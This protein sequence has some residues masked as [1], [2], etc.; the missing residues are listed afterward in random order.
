MLTVA[1][2]AAL[3]AALRRLSRRPA[4]LTRGS[5]EARAAA[6]RLG[7]SVCHPS[8]PHI[9]PAFS[10]AWGLSVAHGARGS[11]PMFGPAALP[12]SAQR[13]QSEPVAAPVAEES[14]LL[15]GRLVHLCH[16][17]G[18]V[19]RQCTGSA[20]AVHRQCTVHAV[21]MQCTCC[22]MCM[23]CACGVHVHADA[24]LTCTTRVSCS[25]L[26]SHAP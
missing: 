16:G 14:L 11:V 26:S 1:L 6:E 21:C 19:H 24:S 25:V 23:Q 4:R 5:R 15:L 18:A 20:Q 10:A 12:Q 9:V 8:P 17:A 3:G 22:A 2:G 7:A 13:A